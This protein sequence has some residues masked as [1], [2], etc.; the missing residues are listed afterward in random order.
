MKVDA[1]VNAANNSLLGG[2]GVDGAIHRAAGPKLLEECRPLGGCDT[3]DAKITGA[4]NLPCKYVIHTVGPIWYGG[5]HGEEELLRSCY[6]RSLS[7]ASSHGCSSVAFPLISSGAY[8]YPKD[9]A[10]R[11]AVST[12]GSYLLNNEDMLVYIVVFDRQAYT[13]EP[14]TYHDI[15]MRLGANDLT[16]GAG[17]TGT[18]LAAAASASKPRLF[19]R[20]MSSERNK[21]ASMEAAMSIPSRDECV[22]ECVKDRRDGYRGEFCA[23]S[24]VC[25]EESADL[26]SR[27]QQIDESFSTMLLRKID[28]SGMTDVE[29]YKRANIDRK[30]FSKIRSDVN[31]RPSKTTV[32]AFAIALRLSIADT[33]DMLM[34]AGFALSRSNRF[35]IIIEYFI[36]KGNYDVFEI[37][38]ALFA[39]DQPLLA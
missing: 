16:S 22:D 32:I 5:Q 38:E 25:M 35:D 10:L 3:G 1:I 19:G 36:E 28:E 9:Q 8:G 26:D 14:G 23:A 31:Y 15:S 12:I 37:N 2:G 24:A 20:K 4:G 27:L 18:G 17:L 33:R 13:I 11:V 34:K 39:F 7:L 29:C 6:N 30:L 21:S